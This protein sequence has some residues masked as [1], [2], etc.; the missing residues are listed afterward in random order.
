MT[1]NNAGDNSL[2]TRSK[3]KLAQRDALL[4]VRTLAE[5]RK[6]AKIYLVLE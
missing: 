5:R 2:A 6:Q 3:E 4:A 1:V